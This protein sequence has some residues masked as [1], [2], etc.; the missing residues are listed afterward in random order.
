MHSI[1]DS[2]LRALGWALAHS[3][4]QG[5]LVA[6]ALLMLLPRV[7]KARQRYWAAYGSLVVV[8]LAAVGTFF[9]KFEPGTE[10]SAASPL[11]QE[12]ASSPIVFLVENQ[13]FKTSFTEYFSQW[14]EANHSLIVAFWLIGF[15]FFLLRLGSGLWQVHVLRTRGTR[16]LEADWQD[17]ISIL[18]G[19]IGVSRVVNLFESALVHTPLTIG[20]LRPA[21]LLPIGF[22]NQ[23][24]IAEVEA[25][26]AHELAH[27]ARRDWVFNLVQAFIESLFYYNPA[28][29]WVSQV[30]RRER[31]NACDDAALAATGNPLAFARAL[32]QVQ[33]MATPLP[34]LAL[35]L[36]GKRRRPLLERVRRILNQAPQQ[37]HQVME[38]I[39]ATVILVV[40][41]ALVGLRANSVPS[42]E[43]AF[44]QIADFPTAF[45]G[46]E[47]DQIESDSLPKP[48]SSKKIT[49][50]DETGRVEAEYKDGELVRLN[51]DGKEIPESEFE[52]HEAV[53][54]ALEEEMPS[55]PDAP[56][57]SWRG[58]TPAPPGAPGAPGAPEAPGAPGAFWFNSP[59]FPAIAPMP[60]MPPFGGG[61]SIETDKDGDGNTIIRLDNHG[62]DTEVVI[63]NGDVWI[64]GKKLEKGEAFDIPGL[65]FG[66][67]GQHFFFD[68]QNGFNFDF[69]EGD[70][71]WGEGQAS[72][73]R[74]RMSPE[75]RERINEEMARAREEHARAMEEYRR[76][77]EQDKK[78]MEK[79]WKNNQKEWEKEQKAWEKEQKNWE[80][81]QR[82]WEREQEKWQAEQ[83][84][85]QAEQQAWEAKSKAAQELLKKELL[86]DGLITDPNNFSLKINAKEL[87]VNKKKQSEELR[88]KYEELIKSSMGAKLEGDD[89]N[90][91][92]NFNDQE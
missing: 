92:F 22:V 54:E 30:I 48:K 19:R 62:N 47:G 50:E 81:E 75:Q 58:G 55:P 61:F 65:H 16:L 17:K 90:Y 9:W 72:S 86:R 20:W 28:V 32:V 51:I 87:K 8:L 5:A 39:T 23:L 79:D 42:I 56:F 33:E 38:K 53:I 41:L 80:K 74:A 84:K 43:A 85:W 78:R 35:A 68:G 21:I 26:L 4:W 7:H 24:S 73:P 44:A 1:P 27:I 83:L 46:G 36:S 34:A 77:L 89:W 37:Q 45:F 88:R 2:L 82:K 71:S 3:L 25:V 12:S 15:I 6:I 52:A 60:P 31:E 11:S 70:F 59:D 18:A 13:Y 49:R 57:F 91:N 69:G 67:D 29:W 14:L 64:D 10:P 40:L 76:D 63:K 66:Q